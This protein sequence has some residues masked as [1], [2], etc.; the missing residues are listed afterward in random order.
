MI[1]RYQSTGSVAAGAEA[2]PKVGRS[3]ESGGTM[4]IK[5]DV[6]LYIQDRLEFGLTH[7]RKVIIR[8]QFGTFDREVRARARASLEKLYYIH[9]RFG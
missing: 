3:Y 7:R 1:V 5:V 9:G 8:L 6:E 2:E 4:L